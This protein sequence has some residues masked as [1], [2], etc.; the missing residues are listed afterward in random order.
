MRRLINPSF[1]P[2]PLKGFEV[3]MNKYY[4][5]FVTGLRE[6]AEKNDG[7]VEMNEWLH[8]LSFDVSAPSDQ[9]NC[10]SPVLW[11]L[12][13]ILGVYKRANDIISSKQSMQALDI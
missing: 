1:G 5:Q 12:E 8:N 9:V 11:L 10:R 7:I 4:D 13:L 3:T 2:T 6:R